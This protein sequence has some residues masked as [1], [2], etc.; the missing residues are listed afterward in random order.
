MVSL[1]GCGVTSVENIT[2]NLTH[3]CAD[4]LYEDDDDLEED[5]EEGG[6]GGGYL[7]AGP[8]LLP[9]CLGGP[10]TNNNLLLSSPGSPAV[11]GGPPDKTPADLQQADSSTERDPNDSEGRSKAFCGDI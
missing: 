4:S 3:G 9:P 5:G 8:L 2:L 7:D 6:G 1:A 11:A 10:E